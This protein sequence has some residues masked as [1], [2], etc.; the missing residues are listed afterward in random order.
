M[1]RKRERERKE[2]LQMNPS[3]GENTIYLWGE[4]K[5]KEKKDDDA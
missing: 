4:K 3:E 2:G 1:G 5:R